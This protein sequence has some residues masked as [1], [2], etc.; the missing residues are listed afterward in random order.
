[1]ALLVSLPLYGIRMRTLNTWLVRILNEIENNPEINDKIDAKIAVEK[2]FENNYCKFGYTYYHPLYR[3]AKLT[4]FKVGEILEEANVIDTNTFSVDSLDK[5]L[6]SY[7]K[8]YAR[9]LFNNF[10]SN[11]T[12][13]QQP[14]TAANLRDNIIYVAKNVLDSTFSNDHETRIIQI[15]DEYLGQLAEYRAYDKILKGYEKS[16]GNS[17]RLRLL[18]DLL[19]KNSKW[20]FIKKK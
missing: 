5:L 7:N 4:L 17:Y 9:Y 20:K 14:S 3:S 19:D 8:P 13:S 10:Q 1:M 15:F 12:A 2:L 16:Y 11:P 18:R 6:K